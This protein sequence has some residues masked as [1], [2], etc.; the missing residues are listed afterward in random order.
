MPV[1]TPSAT[2]TRPAPPTEPPTAAP[3]DTPIPRPTRVTTAGRPTPTRKPG[4]YYEEKDFRPA[5]TNTPT[6]TKGPR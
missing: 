6:P 5:V 1:A 3:T 2:R 4:V